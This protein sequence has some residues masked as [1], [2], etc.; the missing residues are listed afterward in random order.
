MPRDPDFDH[1]QWHDHP[2]NLPLPEPP[3]FVT[4]QISGIRHEVTNWYIADLEGTGFFDFRVVVV[5]CG[6]VIALGD[7]KDK[8][9]NPVNCEKE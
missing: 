2:G 7:P 4:E 1:M 3:K 5:K 6:K 8:N 9:L